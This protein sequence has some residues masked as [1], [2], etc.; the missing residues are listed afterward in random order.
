MTQVQEW[1]AALDGPVRDFPVGWEG[2]EAVRD[3][4]V[5]LMP[6]ARAGETYATIPVV[7]GGGRG[8]VCGAGGA[9]FFSCAFAM[10][11]QVRKLGSALP[12]EFWHLG[13]HEMDPRMEA[14]ARK[15]GIVVM[16]V[17]RALRQHNITP[18]MLNG[19][20]LKPMAA[21][22]S[23]F[24]E[25]LYL[26]A[27][28][29]P[30][31]KPDDL[32]FCMPYVSA[33]AAFWPDLPPTDRPEWM[34]DVVWH[35]VGLPPQRGPDF[36][37]GQFM[38]NKDRHAEAL[39]LTNFFNQHSDWYYK[40]V[41]GDK[42]TFNL[43]WRACGSSFAMPAR[44]A[45]WEHPCIVQHDWH[46]TPLFYHAC[47]GKE[48][49]VEGR[50][51]HLPVGQAVAEAKALRDANWCGRIY[52]WSEMDVEAA[53][54]ASRLAGTYV[55]SRES[56]G[57]RQLD[58]LAGGAIG[59][60][61]AN[62]EKR[63]SVVMRDGTPEIVVVGAAHKGS[64]IAMFFAAPTGPG[65][66][67]G[68]WNAYE[69]DRCSLYL[70]DVVAMPTFRAGTQDE[71]IWRSVYDQNEYNLREPWRA[72]VIDIGAHI[73]AFSKFAVD[74][75]KA[76]QVIAVEPDTANFR[77]L[78][79][80]VWANADVEVVHAAVAGAADQWAY[81]RG[82]PDPTNTGGCRFEPRPASGP[83]AVTTVT[84]AGLLKRC[85]HRPVLVKIDCEG[86]EYDILSSS[87]I[88]WS[89]INVVLGEYHVDIG[90]DHEAK[91][92]ELR[93]L[94]EAKG[95]AFSSHATGDYLGLFASHRKG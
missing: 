82:N 29:L 47:Q 39:R 41:Y 22:L 77:L 44:A 28:C 31:Q 3:A 25:V 30:A 57:R 56:G 69:R 48:D 75:L 60:G 52:D 92:R 63:W 53:S 24:D 36:E 19:W 12:I 38:V 58:L 72:S 11:V 86:A 94:L 7:R 66:Y 45:S 80:N 70:E 8:I 79:K 42:S 91:V 5:A 85:R 27:D 78:Q 71:N 18:R 50:L 49:I 73:G 64:E 16:D 10:A 84:L 26:D 6:R 23:K 2:L 87:D 55:Y 81:P 59:V 32:F 14:L 4:H 51:G 83:Q 17:S 76:Y 20:E 54:H 1:I 89:P 88:D 61:R 9:K 13:R 65:R 67:E 68:R 34:P 95:F 37:S 35:N 90:E 21:S 40:F 43:A 46:G 93:Q 15:Y 62:C 33:G 74:Y